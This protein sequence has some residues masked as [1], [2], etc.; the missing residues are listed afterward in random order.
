MNKNIV[1]S[2]VGFLMCFSLIFEQTKAEAAEIDFEKLYTTG[3]GSPDE[4]LKNEF[5]LNETPYLFMQLPTGEELSDFTVSFWHGPT[6]N[7]SVM[8]FGGAGLT[9]WATPANWDAVKE[10]DE[11]DIDASWYNSGTGNGGTGHTSFTV[12]PE[13]IAMILFMVGGLP[14][15]TSLYRNRRK[16]AIAV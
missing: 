14:I 10:V 8:T 9:R 15:A 5:T 12:T 13:P 16:N 7:T 1:I 3:S 11:W 2:I 4:V 6:N